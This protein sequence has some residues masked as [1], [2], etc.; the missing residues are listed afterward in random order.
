M[1]HFNKRHYEAIATVCQE[2]RKHAAHFVT[3]DQRLTWHAELETRLADMFRA[4][5][6]R[7]DRGRFLHACLPGSNVKARTAHLKVS[8]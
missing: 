4:D 5:N 2:Y 8:A 6:D 3:K 7:F 1:A